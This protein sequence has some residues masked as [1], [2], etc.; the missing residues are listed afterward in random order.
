MPDTP[1]DQ[2]YTWESLRTLAGATGGTFAV[3][4]ALS[5]AFDFS[6]KWLGLAVA[7]AI[8]VG[9]LAYIG[10]LRADWPVAV[11]N[12]CLVFLSAAGATGAANGAINAAKLGLQ[13]NF[14]IESVAVVLQ[15]WS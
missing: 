3:T 2:F 13:K 8:C 10:R 9:T 5:T 12:G 15:P 7:Q 6:P 14:E 4:N 11:L 1:V